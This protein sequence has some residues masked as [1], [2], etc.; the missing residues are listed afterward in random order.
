MSTFQWI[1]FKPWCWTDEELTRLNLESW[2]SL[3]TD[4]KHLKGFP[5]LPKSPTCQNVV[6]QQSLNRVQTSKFIS[7]PPHSTAQKQK[8]DYEWMG[9]G[10]WGVLSFPSEEL[11]INL[12]LF[13]VSKI[14]NYCRYKS[15]AIET[16][17]NH[18]QKSLKQFFCLW[19]IV[20]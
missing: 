19:E 15:V 6:F 11:I 12:N 17:R 3:S 2:I 1:I 4:C 13:P 8:M 14:V 5:T 18:Q 10:G 16:E 20:I 7:P 9:G